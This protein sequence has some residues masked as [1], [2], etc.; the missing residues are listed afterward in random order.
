MQRRRLYGISAKTTYRDRVGG[1]DK[2]DEH[3][4]SFDLLLN[5]EQRQ[6]DAI[7]CYHHCLSSSDL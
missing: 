7:F 4:L 6:Q 1:P 5:G 2:Q 3:R